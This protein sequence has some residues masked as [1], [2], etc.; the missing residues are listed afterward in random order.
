MPVR[1]GV[2]DGDLSWITTTHWSI[3]IGRGS[4]SVLGC[5]LRKTTPGILKSPINLVCNFYEIHLVNKLL[6]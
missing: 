5:L 4:I 1:S 3:R 6:F 2:G